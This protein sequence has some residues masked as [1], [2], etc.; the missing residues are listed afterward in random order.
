M[1]KSFFKT[2][3]SEPSKVFTA[4][5]FDAVIGG[6]KL[7]LKNGPLEHIGAFVDALEVTPVKAEE[8]ACRD[9]VGNEHVAIEVG[10]L[11]MVSTMSVKITTW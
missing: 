7:G 5:E 6:G 8:E 2:W 11:F 9:D 4:Q 3:L 1:F 10:N